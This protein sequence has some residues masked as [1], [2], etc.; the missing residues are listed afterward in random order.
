[1][2]SHADNPCWYVLYTMPHHEKSVC[3]GLTRK[4]IEAHFLV[5]KE[6]R[7][8]SDRKRKMEVPVFPNYIFLQIRRGDRFKVFEI[9]G[10]VRYLDSNQDPT[11]IPQYEIDF[12]LQLKNESY[13]VTNDAFHK[14]DQ[15][16]IESGPLRNWK[17]IL[18]EKKGTKRL[19]VEISSIKRN[20]LIDVSSYQ[21]K[22]INCP[23]HERET[24]LEESLV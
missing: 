11:V 19:L 6:I 18:V 24:L 5:R 17:G 21:L 4:G 7:Q 13:E 15:V 1:M 9:P 23:I 8:W 20:L 3:Q 10:I 22:K 14:G 12:I 16:V 2:I